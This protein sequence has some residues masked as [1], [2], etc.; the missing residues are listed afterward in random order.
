M[1]V[2]AVKGQMKE[3]AG[4]L[5]GDKGMEA[6]G[7]F[8]QGVAALKK[9]VVYVVDLVGTGINTV[10]NAVVD[11]YNSAKKTISKML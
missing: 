10:T 8:E 1:S 9:P 6:E 2:Q 5:T 7:L 11:V 3:A 4:K